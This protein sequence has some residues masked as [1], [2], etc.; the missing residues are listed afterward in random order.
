LNKDSVFKVDI[1]GGGRNTGLSDPKTMS[2]QYMQSFKK[3]GTQ[4]FNQNYNSR[5]TIR[6]KDISDSNLQPE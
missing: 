4:S 1:S 5:S 2:N 6:K 3:N